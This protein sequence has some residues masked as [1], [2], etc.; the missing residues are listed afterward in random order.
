MQTTLQGSAD[1]FA[2]GSAAH[3]PVFKWEG[4]GNDKYFARMGKN[5]ISV[6]EVCC[7]SPI[8]WIQSSSRL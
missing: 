2:M 4:S 6:Y 7:L 8:P 1:E 3:W 5:C